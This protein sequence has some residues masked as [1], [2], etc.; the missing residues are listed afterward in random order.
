MSMYIIYERVRKLRLKG[1]GREPK[2]KISQSQALT[3]NND[4]PTEFK[5]NSRKRNPKSK[6]F[7]SMFY[8]VSLDFVAN[9]PFSSVIRKAS[10][11]FPF[12]F[13]CLLLHLLSLL[14]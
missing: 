2:V 1:S 5:V 8:K 13:E 9:F 10:F 12:P 6:C 14:L 3:P 4:L 11:P 7:L